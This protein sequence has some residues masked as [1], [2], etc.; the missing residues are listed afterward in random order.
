MG[1]VSAVKAGAS[2]GPRAL[3]GYRL[4]THKTGKW[5]QLVP[6]HMGPTQD[7]LDILLIVWRSASS[8]VASI[9][10]QSSE[11]SR[12]MSHKDLS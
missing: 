2:E 9:K 11:D 7:C 6:L 10:D 1:C 12:H 3:W 8:G 4:L 5:V